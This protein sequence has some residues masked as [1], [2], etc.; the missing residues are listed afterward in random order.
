MKKQNILLLILTGVVLTFCSNNAYKDSAKYLIKNFDK[1]YGDCGSA[2]NN[3]V[4]I[5]I[6]YPT[7][8]YAKNQAVVDT[9]NARISKMILQPVFQ[10]KSK[11]L[12]ELSDTLINDYK[13]FKKKF[14]DSPSRYELERIVN[15]L[16]NQHG[17]ISLE[18]AE[19]Y[20][21][22]GAHPNSVRT[23]LNINAN[24]GGKISLSDLLISGFEK[25]INNIAEIEF[26][27]VRLLKPDD[28]LGK[29]GFWFK[30]NKFLLNENFLITKDGLTFYFN[31]YEIAPHSVG[32]T[33]IKLKYDEIKDLI[34]PEGLL[35]S[36]LK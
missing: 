26:R 1:S 23:F 35:A 31:D 7:F 24:S 25:R 28:D 2:S 8:T 15:V 36:K 32:P 20:F 6:E 21:L 3:C 18:Y 14:P 13:R 22:G 27:K 9:L 5:S 11:S 29:A 10:V 19:N 12:E 17:I 33:E 30:D 16:L 34:N 4:T